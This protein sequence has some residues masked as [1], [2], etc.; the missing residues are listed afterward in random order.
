MRIVR[1]EEEE[2]YTKFVEA[3]GAC[4]RQDPLKQTYAEGD[5]RCDSLL[6]IRWN[7]ATILVVK[8]D[9]IEE[10]RLYPFA[11]SRQGNY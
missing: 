3:A 4:F 5:P 9:Q 6:A 2:E 8:I 1:L 10:P 11:L 7:E